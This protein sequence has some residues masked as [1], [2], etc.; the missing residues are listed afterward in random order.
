[1]KQNVKN[2]SHEENG[3]L[4]PLLIILAIGAAAYVSLLVYA[5]R[6]VD[7][8]SQQSQLAQVE[9]AIKVEH[10]RLKDQLIE[11]I[12]WDEAYDRLIT[13][14]D[15]LWASENLGLYLADELNIDLSIVVDTND[16]LR[17]VFADGEAQDSGFFNSHQGGLTLLV[18][19]AR[20]F[21]N[22]PPNPQSGYDQHW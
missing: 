11:H 12:Y 14:S 18:N 17:F 5:L 4:A 20:A 16:E 3:I 2:D 13:K 9:A 22:A 7:Q 19:E 21:L 1:M 8:I 10:T 15:A 6:Q